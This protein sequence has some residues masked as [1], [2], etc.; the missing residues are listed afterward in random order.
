MLYRVFNLG[1]P[2]EP[3]FFSC[4]LA[5]RYQLQES[6]GG[7]GGG[8]DVNR[9][10]GRRRTKQQRLLLTA[11]VKELLQRPLD[12]SYSDLEKNAKRKG[13]AYRR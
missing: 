13:K 10:G 4:L 2:E 6:G 8:R 9:L 1:I 12:C 5:F 7:N 3:M 11:A